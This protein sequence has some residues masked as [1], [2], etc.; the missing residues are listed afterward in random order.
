MHNDGVVQGAAPS[1]P[2]A[3]R[4]TLARTD[5]W[6][7]YRQCPLHHGLEK[8][9]D[10]I[11]PVVLTSRHNV[12]MTRIPRYGAGGPI[13]GEN[14]G[15]A[16]QRAKLDRR[17]LA[18][19][20]DPSLRPGRAAAVAN[21]REHFW[22]IICLVNS[23]NNGAIFMR[24]Q[25]RQSKT[26]VAPSPQAAPTRTLPSGLPETGYALIVDGRA[27]SEF[28]IKEGA[29]K[30]ARELKQRFPMLQIK[31]YDAEANRSEEIVM[32]PAH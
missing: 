25:R 13:V 3:G 27:K 12:R 28:K 18:Q 31:V 29:E 15:A 24:Q 9:T 20:A 8:A 14:G 30:E 1:P 26:P 16:P 21:P 23:P 2:H 7:G 32:T 17:G 19:G 5:D 10:R 22:Q 6:H 11:S 4:E